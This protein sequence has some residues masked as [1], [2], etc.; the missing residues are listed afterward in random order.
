M[1]FRIALFAS[2]FLVPRSVVC[3]QGPN[4]PGGIRIDAKGVIQRA[5]K[6]KSI[7]KTAMRAAAKKLLSEDLNRKTDLR[8]VSLTQLDAECARLIEA[9]ESIPKEVQFL[10]GLQRVDYVM[11]LEESK[12]VIIAGPADGFAANSDGVMVG[13]SSGRPVLR[14]DDL[15]QAMGAVNGHIRC[16]FD[17]KPEKLAEVNR[18]LQ[19]VGAASSVREARKRY[20]QMEKMLGNQIVSIGGVDPTSHLA[21]TLVE[22]DYMLKRIS[23]GLQKTKVRGMKSYLEMDSAGTNSMRRWWFAPDYDALEY[24]EDRTVWKING[25]RV[26]VKSQDELVDN[27]GKR[28]DTNQRKQSTRAFQRLFTEKYPE[29]AKRFDVFARLQNT[30]DLAIVSAL[31][32][33]EGLAKRV[34]WSIS[35][36]S[37]AS[38]LAPV[39]FDVPRE[40][41][42]ASSSRTAGNYLVVGVVSGGVSCQP[43]LTL[44]RMEKRET[45]RMAS[46][47]TSASKSRKSEGWWWDAE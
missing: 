25:Q 7:S 17:P 39:E 35:A 47:R 3:A 46:Q 16:S 45:P 34:N 27:K 44:A 19:S 15:V 10:A 41:P 26:Q 36:L 32:Q 29:L 37:Q 38:K 4:Q 9:G 13:V 31:I 11:V 2:L 14:L 12:E 1:L 22:A 30:F 24:S 6:S 20:E 43:Q 5:R 8:F 21:R 42:T 28:R 18:Y 40:V 33:S 23:V